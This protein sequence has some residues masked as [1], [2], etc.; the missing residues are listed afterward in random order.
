ME[1]DCAAMLRR[2]DSIDWPVMAVLTSY[3]IVL[4][5]IVYTSQICLEIQSKHFNFTKVQM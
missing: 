1:N 3:A 4:P 5:A 2:H